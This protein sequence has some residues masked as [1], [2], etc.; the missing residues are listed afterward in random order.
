RERVAEAGA[1][2]AAVAGRAARRRLAREPSARA[3]A[4]ELEARVPRAGR[5][6]PPDPRGSGRA[7]DDPRPR[8]DRR[9]DDEVG[10]GRGPHR[11]KGLHGRVEEARAMKGRRSPG[12]QRPYP[13]TMIC[14]VYRVPRSSVYG[15]AAPTGPPAPASK[16]G[17][18]TR[19]SDA[20]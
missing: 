3:R 7:R 4:G 15:A 18:R 16:P 8:Q 17:P 14:A 12:T 20:A 6:E 2:A 19:Q 5:A 1:G 13:L 10:A 11:K 9:I